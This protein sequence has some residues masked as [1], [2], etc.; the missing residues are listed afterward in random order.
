MRR[1]SRVTDTLPYARKASYVTTNWIC[2]G[3]YFL[4]IKIRSRDRFIGSIFRRAYKPLR[5][6]VYICF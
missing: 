4:F 1:P 2:G 3:I 5:L 6:L